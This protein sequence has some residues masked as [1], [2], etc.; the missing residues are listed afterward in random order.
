[1]SA[2]TEQAA[3]ELDALRAALR[4]EGHGVAPVPNSP[5]HALNVWANDGGRIPT[6]TVI[7]EAGR[8]VW[9]HQWEHSVG[10]TSLSEAVRAIVGSFP[11]KA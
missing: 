9:G 10:S 11:K 3:K 7:Y 4:M 6:C 8:F 1:M 2:E 5:I